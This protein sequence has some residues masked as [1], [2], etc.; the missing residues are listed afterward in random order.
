MMVTYIATVVAVI[1]HVVETNMIIVQI[2][3]RN[4]ENYVLRGPMVKIRLHAAM[5]EEYQQKRGVGAGKFISENCIPVNHV[6]IF[7]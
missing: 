6:R 1:N 3:T 7:I 2:L 5:I 4:I